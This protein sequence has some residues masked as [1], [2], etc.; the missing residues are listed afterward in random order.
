MNRKSNAYFIICLLSFSMLPVPTVSAD[1]PILYN[2]ELSADVGLTGAFFTNDNA[3]GFYVSLVDEN[4][5]R[6]NS[7]IHYIDKTIKIKKTAL[8]SRF[9]KFNGINIGVTHISDDGIVNNYI[10]PV[11]VDGEFVFI[12]V[13]FST[14]IINGMTGTTT[15]TLTGLSGNQS[16]SV[17]NGSSYDL[18]ITNNQ[19]GVWTINGTDFTKRRLLTLNNS[20]EALTDFQVK[21]VQDYYSGMQVDMDDR[22][23]T[24]Y[25]NDTLILFWDENVINSTNVTSW[26]KIPSIST[27]TGAKVRMYYGN[28]NLSSASSIFDTGIT[29]SDDFSKGT[30]LWSTQSGSISITSEIASTYPTAVHGGVRST[31]TFNLI[32]GII[33]EARQQYEDIAD[34]QNAIAITSIADAITWYNQNSVLIRATGAQS[35]W[36]A[37]GKTAYVLWGADT[38]DTDWH[39]MKITTKVG[40]DGIMEVSSETGTKSPAWNIVDSTYYI[41]LSKSYDAPQTSHITKTDWIF[42]R[43]YTATEPTW[44]AD[45]EEQTASGTTNITVSVTGDSNEQSYNT[46]QSREFTLTPTG[47]TSNVLV[48]TTSTDYDTTITTYWTEDTTLIEETVA[49][50][51]VK[52]YINYTPSA[53]VTSAVLNSTILNDLTTHDYLGTTTSTLNDV[54]KTTTRALQ[55]VNASVGSLTKNVEYLWNITIPYNNAP[56][57]GVISNQ[58]AYIGVSKSFTAPSYSDPEGLAIDTHYWQ[59]GDGDNSSNQNPTHTYTS[60]GAYNANYTVTETATVSPQAVLREFI[61]DVEVQPP[62]NVTTVPQQTNVSID[63]DD[64]ASADKYS[65]YELEDGISYVTTNP[66]VDGVKDAIYDS[67]HEFLIYSPN[68]ETQGD[69]ETSYPVRT[70]LGAYFFHE[71]IDNDDKLGDDD[72]IYYFDTDNDGLTVDDPAW[73]ITNN[74]VKKY[75]WNGATWQVTGVSS[76]VGESTGGGSHYPKHEL[77]IPVAELGANWTNGSTVKVLVKREDSALSP[78]V[79][80][81]Y[82]YGNI[83]NTDTSLWQELVLNQPNTYN[84]LANVTLSNYTATNLTPFTIYHGAVSSWNG[85][86]ESDYTLFDVITDDVP[87]YNVSGYVFDTDGNPIS[88]ATVYSCNGF[89]HETTTTNESGYWIGYNFRDGTYTIYA[90]A[91]GYYENSIEVTVAG[92]NLTEQNITL[93]KVPVVPLPNM[94]YQIFLMLM[95]I[96]MLA[97]YY[98]FVNIDTSYY[99]DITTSLLSCIISF[100]IAHNSIIGV[101]II[102]ALHTSVQY[103]TYSS[104]PLCMLFCGVGTTMLILFIVKILELTHQELDQL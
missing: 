69:Y 100:I 86:D 49:S 74:I 73:K 19:D 87:I 93:E 104:L 55:E 15:T 3:D 88:E 83:N 2:K 48:N 103:D 35:S 27:T 44:V 20:S 8:D 6:I 4:S 91:A 47:T 65:V 5:I 16:I 60:V 72:L 32:D 85:T 10:S 95:I 102:Y 42:I 40:S 46:S 101:C 99:T 14:V 80:T 34:T 90:N 17:P 79:V 51:Y 21:K 13:D 92:A 64:Y 28:P 56:T 84:L 57:V 77:F 89:V 41:W 37:W 25:E 82:P 75:L 30:T 7:D 61:V 76:A 78:D 29:G 63:W 1:P 18:N 98:S 50:G 23:Y 33:V 66:T 94:P 53:N 43:K 54:S 12:T 9:K 67:A 96:N 24:I 38:L 26:L 62:Q 52:Q 68:P 11:V 31:N 39:T 45:G 58:T 71:A 97:V 81:W 36:E 59:F 70:A 22:L